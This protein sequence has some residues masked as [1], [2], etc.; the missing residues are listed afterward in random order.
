M[1]TLQQCS[2]DDDLTNRALIVLQTMK[3]RFVFNAKITKLSLEEI[4]VFMN[5]GDYHGIIVC[6]NSSPTHEA[7]LIYLLLPSVSIKCGIV[8]T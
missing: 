3:R 2:S 6:P 8:Y 5:T 1:N 7:T 4:A